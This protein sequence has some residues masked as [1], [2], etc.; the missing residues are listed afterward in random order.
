MKVNSS[1][2]VLSAIFAVANLFQMTVAQIT[3]VESP[4][5]QRQGQG[6]QGQSGLSPEKKKSLSK[7]GPEDAFPGAREQDAES[8]RSNRPASKQAASK[9]QP[10]PTIEPAP[11]PASTSSTVAASSPTPASQF[12]TPMATA[13]ALTA[14]STKAVQFNSA[15]NGKSGTSYL[16]PAALSLATVLVFGALIYV[17]G[18]LRKKLKSES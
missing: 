18:I 5:R 12:P 4:L 8:R 15:E 6:A 3:F 1:V 17:V 16:V 2:L 14:S 10:S 7:Y 11:S 13:A 9:P